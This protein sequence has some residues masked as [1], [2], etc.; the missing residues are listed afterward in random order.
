[1]KKLSDAEIKGYSFEVLCAIRDI[2]DRHQIQYS[3]TGGTLIGAV[4][5]KGF[6]P[7]D[8]D[9][10]IMMPRPDYDRFIQIVKD[11]G[12]LPI[13]VLS[14]ELCGMAY[15]YAFAKACHPQTELIEKDTLQSGLK[16]GVYVDIFPVDGIGWKYRGAKIRTMMF[17][18]LHGL[19][20]SSNWTKF[21]RSKLRKWYY[22]PFRFVCYV[23]SRILGR[24]LIDR[25]LDRFVRKI[26]Y[27]D[28]RYAGRLVGDYGSR[29]IM[30]KTL[31]Q[32]TTK[33]EFEGEMFDAIADYDTFLR[34]LYGDYMQLPPEEKRV[35]H[36]EFDAY[37]IG[38]YK[39]DA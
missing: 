5:H 11:D 28:A 13:R 35:T 26:P 4:R 8:D 3:L 16:L 25:W 23:V 18:F 29:E 36:H 7:W 9:I 38:E 19:K 17:Q 14:A 31:F 39:T 15:P 27:S 2:C 21:R 22:E 20:I 6:I 10:D 12:E 30:Q 33:V 1:M 34:S 37:L 24:R 32:N